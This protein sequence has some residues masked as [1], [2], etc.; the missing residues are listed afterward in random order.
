MNETDFLFDEPSSPQAAATADKEWL[1]PRHLTSSQAAALNC[2]AGMA[3]LRGQADRGGVRLRNKALIVGPSASGKSA[4]VRRLADLEDLPL[5]VIQCGVW[6]PE[7]AAVGA[8]P[9][10]LSIIR[11][12]VQMHPTGCIFLDEIDKV[13]PR[14]AFSSSWALGSFSEVVSLLDADAKL[15]TSGW[16]PDQ[17]RRLNSHLLVAAGTWQIHAASK[18]SGKNDD[19]YVDRIIAQAGIPDEIRLR[20][21]PR[22]VELKPP[23][24]KDLCLATCPTVAL[25]TWGEVG[26]SRVRLPDRH[27]FWSLGQ[28]GCNAIHEHGFPATEPTSATKRRKEV[29]IFILSE[30][31]NTS[32]ALEPDGYVPHPCRTHRPRSDLQKFPAQPTVRTCLSGSTKIQHRITTRPQTALSPAVKG[33]LRLRPSV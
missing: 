22:L 12:F 20:F 26:D 19:G 8:G 27:T 10:T 32:L 6:T 15:E 23:T 1:G 7:G 31:E 4:L 2:L 14:D 24:V 5:L 30:I 3:R 16:R 9:H 18:I 33:S 21:H 17:I 25:T 11:R 13:C 28:V 29:G